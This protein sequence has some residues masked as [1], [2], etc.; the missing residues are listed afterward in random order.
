MSERVRELADRERALRLHCAAQRNAIAREVTGLETR[1]ATVDRV[2]VATRRVLTHPAAIGGGLLVLIL[3][4][5][6]R[7]FRLLGQGL[8]LANAARRLLRL[9]SFV[10]PR[11]DAAAEPYRDA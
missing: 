2:A 8:L 7:T 3:L 10:I 11:R 9:G 4:G 6:A 1:L 5:R